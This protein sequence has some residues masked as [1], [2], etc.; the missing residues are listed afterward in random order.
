MKALP[1]VNPNQVLR[2]MRTGKIRPVYLLCGEEGYLIELTLEKMLDILLPEKNL[3]G[4]NLTVF[5]GEAVSFD[6]VLSALRTYPIGAGRR[7]VLVRNPS[8]LSEGVNPVE[9]LRGGMEAI[10]KG[11]NAKGARLIC[12]ALNLSGEELADQAALQRAVARFKEENAGELGREEIEFLD[13]LG[14]ILCS[15]D[16]PSVRS[17]SADRDRFAEW[18]R[19]NPS[20]N[21]VLI[22]TVSGLPDLRG[23]LMEA[24]EGVGVIINF[25]HLRISSELRSDPM[26][27]AVSRYLSKFGKSIS[28]SAFSLLRERCENDLGRVMEELEKLISF[29][30]DR[31]TIER[32]D[33]EAVVAEEVS[34]RMFELVDAIGRRDIPTALKALRYTLQSGEPPA[35]TLAM[36][37]RQIRLILQA[38]L[39]LEMGA[40]RGD[41]RAMDYDTISEALKNV[42]EQVAR[43]LP[44]SRKHNLLK[45]KPFPIL[46]ALRLSVNFTLDDLKR[47][48]ERVLEADVALKTGGTPEM[49]LEDLVIDLCGE[50]VRGWRSFR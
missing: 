24:I 28:P 1:R 38:K 12:R 40:I 34:S 44:E 17:G 42:P 41:V 21:S 36:I 43:L 33:V 48:M 7:V 14:E 29:V 30:G 25:T 8:F 3:R 46:Q 32:A 10:R 37:A 39:L 18:L 31:E 11:A 19:S 26:F 9:L 35:K 2:E 22:L 5:D 45:Q 6:E 15:I 49:V 16:L 50:G 47:A 20:P 23:G 13:K 4:F 27:K